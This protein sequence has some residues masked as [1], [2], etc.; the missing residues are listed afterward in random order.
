[1]SETNSL[2]FP[3]QTTGPTRSADTEATKALDLAGHALFER[4]G[5]G[6]M[7]E[8]YR[9]ADDTLQRDLAIKILKVELRGDAAVEAAFRWVLCG[10]V[11]QK[12][13]RGRRFSQAILTTVTTAITGRIRSVT[14]AS[15]AAGGEYGGHSNA[16][17]WTG[18]ISSRL[19]DPVA[20]M[21]TISLNRAR[22]HACRLVNSPA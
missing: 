15:R 11:A 8:V 2:N 12:A 7:G 9:C 4:I 14:P 5:L 10:R 6:G 22:R 16:H 18:C 13:R 21:S 17:Q 3:D 19:V 1:M 20:W